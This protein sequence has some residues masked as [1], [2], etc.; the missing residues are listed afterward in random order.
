MAK[1]PT[2]PLKITARLLDGRVNSTDGLLFL[3]S[4]LYHAWFMIHEPGV[5]EGT[6]RR[7]DQKYIGLPLRQ[8]PGNRNAASVGQYTLYEETVEHWVKRPDFGKSFADQY[9]DERI[10]KLNTKSGHLK[11][12]RTPQVIRVISD[13]VFYAVGNPDRI[14][15]MLGYMQFIGKKGSIGWGAVKEWVVEPC[16]ADYSLIKDGK[17]MRPVPVEEADALNFDRSKTVKLMCAVRPPY[18][19]PKNA[20]L[21]YVPKVGFE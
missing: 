16:E 21:C 17:L 14:R 8:E 13:V 18:W 2:V 10:G 9:L 19:K 3:D 5:L 4:I 15:E 1:R 7:D 6:V 20:R 11:A 12:Y